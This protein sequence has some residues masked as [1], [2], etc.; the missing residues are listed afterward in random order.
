MSLR[1]QMAGFPW[2]QV[3][4]IAFVRFAEPIAF[5]SLF[6][7]VYFMIQDFGVAKDNAEI[8]KYSGYLASAFA[9]CQV[10]TSF[11]WG[12]L[13]DKIGRKPVLITGLTGTALSLLMLG[14]AKSFHWA[15]IARC[16]M[17]LLNGN[18]GVI[19]TVLGE[20]AKNEN[21][22]SLVFATMPLVYQL[23]AVIGPLIGGNLSGKTTRFDSLRPLVE[24]FPYALPNIVAAGFLILS[25]FIALFFLEE[26]HWDHKYRHD[27]FLDF[28]DT[29]L[30]KL[31]KVNMGDRPWRRSSDTEAEQS[32][33]ANDTV[34]ENLITPE[35]PDSVT[36]ETVGI[37]DVEQEKV[38]MTYRDLLEPQI[39]YGILCIFIAAIHQTVYNEFAAIFLSTDIVRDDDGKLVSRFPFKI[40]GGL[41]YS[42]KVTGVL[43][44]STGFTGAIAVVVALPYVTRNFK[45]L[46]IYRTC[47]IAFPV[48]YI[49]LPYLVFLAD[50]QTLSKVASYL[51]SATRALT[52]AM[53]IPQIQVTINNSAPKRH[54]AFV[55]GATVSTASAA[56]CGGPFIWGYLLSW[57]QRLEIA[58]F[59]WWMLA[60][61]A[62]VNV[63]MSRRIREAAPSL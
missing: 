63:F 40:V 13:A 22:Q 21:N 41:G 34:A 42:S 16:F 11:R 61:V 30:E 1:E 26:T 2:A 33:L 19:R 18:V 51:L 55:N 20:I 48:I 46:S 15:L 37:Q 50:R 52:Q 62:T 44:S 43:L 5:T 24:S 29:I 9:F 25:G 53:S 31:F 3:I 59:G 58:W 12:R 60:L 35:G 47:I 4:V 27:Y 6:T 7:Y 14:F 10:L 57:G 49:L 45:T 36:L 56:R 17:G 28:S 54:R 39:F 32:L 23:G 38:N 8:S